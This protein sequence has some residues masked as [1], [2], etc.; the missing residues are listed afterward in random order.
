MSQGEKLYAGLRKAVTK[1]LTTDWA[2]DWFDIAKSAHAGFIKDMQDDA[3]VQYSWNLMSA[4]NKKR[5]NLEFELQIYIRSDCHRD[6]E[7]RNELG[8]QKL[9]SDILVEFAKF[10]DAEETERLVA[11]SLTEFRKKMQKET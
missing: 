4:S 5:K 10:L 8:K 7:V 6:D 11:N 3:K 2:P 9:L 1:S